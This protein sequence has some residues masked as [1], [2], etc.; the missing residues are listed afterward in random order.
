MVLIF[1]LQNCFHILNF[2][3]GHTVILYIYSLKTV[4]HS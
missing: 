3:M 4:Q 1:A 2:F